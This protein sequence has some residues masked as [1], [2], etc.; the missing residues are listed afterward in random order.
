ML[1][2]TLIKRTRPPAL[3]PTVSSWL[4]SSLNATPRPLPLAHPAVAAYATRS[5]ST[6]DKPRSRARKVAP[7]AQKTEPEIGATK[8]VEEDGLEVLDPPQG[9][10]LRPYQAEAIRAVLD[11]LD[12][13]KFQRLG[14][15]MPTGS[16]KTAIFTALIR[17]LPTLVHP[18]SG[19]HADRVLIIVNSIQ[20]ALQTAEVV[21]RTYPDISVEIE[22]GSK[23]GTGMAQVTVATYQTLARGELSRLDKFDPDSFKAVIVDEAHHAAAPSYLAILS[24]FDSHILSDID[25]NS[26]T[27]ADNSIP[28]ASPIAPAPSS[29]PNGEIAAAESEPASSVSV[30]K[31]EFASTLFPSPAPTASCESAPEEDDPANLLPIPVP[32]PAVLDAEGRHRVP[33]LAFTATWGRA[34]GLALGKVWERIVYHAEW[35]DMIDA[36]W[37]SPLRFTTVHLSPSELDLSSVETSSSTGDFN[38]VSLAKAVDQSAINQIAVDAWEAKAKDRRST[39]VFAVNIAHVISLTNEF[40]SRGIDAR[41]VYEATKQKE[42]EEL[43]KAFRDGE[44]PVLVNCSILTEGVDMP[45]VDAILLTRPTKSQNLFLQ[46]LGRGLR[47]SPGTGKEDCLLIDLVGSSTGG[48]ACVPTLFGLDP[49][50]KIDD[51][52]TSTLRERAVER[53]LSSPPSSSDQP[54]AANH[55]I[56]ALSPQTFIKRHSF[57]Y[58]DYETAFDLVEQDQRSGMRGKKRKKKDGVE[59]DEGDEGRSEWVPVSRLSRLAWVGCGGDTWVLELMGHGHVKVA[60]EGDV[61]VASL[62]RRL[63]SLPGLR[64]PPYSA[65]KTLALH[66]SL[67]ILLRTTDAIIVNNP[68]YRDMALTRYAPWRG[69]DA[70]DAQKRFVMKKL[71]KDVESSS[72]GD[73]AAGPVAGG[74]GEETIEGVW[75]GQPWTARVPVSTLTKGQASDLI[76]R[77]T[78]GGLKFWRENRKVLV[79]E[80]KKEKRERDKVEKQL[81]KIREKAEK[82]KQKE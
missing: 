80:E 41:F 49:S 81:A 37:L 66:R 51:D 13:G 68:E 24:R 26:L 73:P 17:Y 12:R 46:M 23:K 22:Q 14:V 82:A 44:F 61:F 31:D 6:S 70:S 38:M 48:I 40:R 42:R 57:H 62:Y 8:G 1:A 54:D 67:P 52:T 11:E 53:A 76:A 39:L 19:E 58:R 78:H 2:R 3:A 63:P 4:P 5:R 21:Q 50:E 55:P 36:S 18:T 16:G 77:T 75:V 74:G 25:R 10:T 64:L 72:L 7:P 20:L 45:H 34:D 65:A 27:S 33:M 59:G 79:R 69:K 56:R 15:S 60:K 9:I 32:R 43:Y 47:L 30:E 28:A 71:G 29:S 35:I